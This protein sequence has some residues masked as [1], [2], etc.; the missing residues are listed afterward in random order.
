MGRIFLDAR[1]KIST[2]GS[3]CGVLRIGG[4]HDLAVLLDRALTLQHLDHD[5]PGHHE[6][7]EVAKKRTFPVNRIEA[8]GLAAAE[9]DHLGCHDPQAR[10]LEACVN[11]A[12]QVLCDSVGFNYREGTFKSH[13]VDPS[14]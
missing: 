1:G 9:M 13:S 5:R 4:A 6:L 11:L 8:L 7:H 2:Q 12:N 14:G 10:L 3:W